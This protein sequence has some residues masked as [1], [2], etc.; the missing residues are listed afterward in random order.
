M[1]VNKAAR[2]RVRGIKGVEGPWG[3]M[4]PDQAQLMRRY[5]YLKTRNPKI[6]LSDVLT[7]TKGR[8][9]KSAFGVYHAL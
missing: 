1:V 3:T 7:G 9:K 2:L 6:T 4:Q 5:E 8:L